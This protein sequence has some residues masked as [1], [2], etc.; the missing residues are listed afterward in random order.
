MEL[1]IWGN[2]Q[3]AKI[4]AGS[5]VM[6]SKEGDSGADTNEF[7]QHSVNI[8]YDFWMAR[9]PITNEQYAEY[10]KGTRGKYPSYDWRKKKDHP[11]VR[12]TW[13]DAMSYCRWMNDLLK[14]QLPPGLVLRLPIEA[15]W[16]KAARGNNELKWP[17]GNEFDTSM[18]NSR[19]GGT[20]GTTPIGLYS[21]RGDSLYGCADMAGNVWEWTHSLY[22]PY[23]YHVDDGREQDEAENVVISSVRVARGGSYYE[24][25]KKARCASRLEIIRNIGWSSSGF[26]TVIAPPL[27]EIIK[28]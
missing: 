7:P 18:C 28:A 24:N 5:F 15:E 21:P 27:S 14:E 9:F 1:M 4:P 22:K 17:W 3:F 2:T 26:R 16:E 10:F 12:A 19:E 25:G 6:G 13:N 23:P 11:V 20:R 8:S